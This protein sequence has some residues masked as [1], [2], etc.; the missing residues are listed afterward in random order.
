MNATQEVLRY[1]INPQI[2]AFFEQ[3]KAMDERERQRQ[4]ELFLVI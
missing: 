4:R 2:N 1:Q 3:L